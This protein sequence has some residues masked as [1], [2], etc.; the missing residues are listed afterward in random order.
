MDCWL[1]TSSVRYFPKQQP[2]RGEVPFVVPWSTSGSRAFSLRPVE[3]C[4]VVTFIQMS[5]LAGVPWRSAMHIVLKSHWLALIV[6]FISLCGLGGVLA[7][8]SIEYARERSQLQ[9]V[10]DDAAISGVLA[11]AS[12]IERGT[13]A[14]Q[15]EAFI[16]A[17]HVIN[18]VDGAWGTIAPSDDLTIS[19]RLSVLQR[20]RLLG[21]IQ[22]ES[23]VE[24]VGTATYLPPPQPQEAL[25]NRLYW[26]PKYAQSRE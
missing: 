5:L 8:D 26:K 22:N 20:S 21:F 10:A 3:R 19:V 15:H 1:E 2:A 11:L 24:V 4:Q 7:I 23:P 13:T 12:N 16:A 9:K 18:R 25:A 6:G 17:S 14:A